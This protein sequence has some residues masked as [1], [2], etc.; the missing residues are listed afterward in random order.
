MC[1]ELNGFIYSCAGSYIRFVF[2]SSYQTFFPSKTHTVRDLLQY[3]LDFSQTSYVVSNETKTFG[4]RTNN[5]PSR[6]LVCYVFGSTTHLP[7]QE[8]PSNDCEND[9]QILKEI[10][11]VNELTHLVKHLQNKELGQSGYICQ[12]WLRYLLI[13]MPFTFKS[14]LNQKEI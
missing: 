10:K 2:C 9:N 6:C 3:I 13:L 11:N 14:D 7:F 12:K 4:I 8:W 5:I 1:Y